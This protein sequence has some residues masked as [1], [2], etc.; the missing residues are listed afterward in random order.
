MNI[1]K[2][3]SLAI[4]RLREPAVGGVSG[5][6][7]VCLLLLYK[8]GSLVPGLSASES[9][10]KQQA[11]SFHVIL[12]NPV[13]LPYKTLQH[14]IGILDYQTP[15]ALRFISALAAATCIYLFYYTLKKWYSPRVAVLG[16]ILFAT[17]SW[18]LHYARLATPD[19]TFT[20]I[21]AVV[22]YGAWIRYTNRHS[23]ALV[24]GTVLAVSLIYV[25]GFIWFVVPGIIW[26][27][28]ALLNTLRHAS[29]PSLG[30]AAVVLAL[31]APLVWS[32]YEN[33]LVLRDIL[34]A[35]SSIPSLGTVI[36]NTLSIPRHLLWANEPNPV[37][38]LDKL[39]LLDVFTIAMFGLGIYS[40]SFKKK[41]DRTKMLAGIFVIGVLGVSL[42]GKINLIV[43]QPAIYLVATA[44]VAL[45]MQQWFTVFPRNPLAR[46]IGISLISLSVIMVAFY[47]TRHY[48]VAWPNSPETK[49]V[50]TLQR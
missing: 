13:F 48:F 4:A 32:V 44:G 10:A 39:P 26:Q 20:A 31:L 15:T 22:A 11:A 18:F 6:L 3:A 47:N 46:T 36:N 9:L 23:L 12:E 33:P 42:G 49:K 34:G 21:I 8:I 41:L 25:P 7:L 1:K 17:S 16:T 28:K 37:V 35:P 5:G 50:F 38:W 45:L 43:L 24:I 19:I 40:Y 29:K 30:I 2:R 14:A 27:R